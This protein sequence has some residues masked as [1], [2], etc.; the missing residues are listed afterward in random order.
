MSLR[1]L[2]VLRAVVEAGGVTRAAELLH[3][4]QPAVSAQLRAIERSFGGQLFFRAG[5]RLTLTEAGERVYQWANEVHSGGV[6]VQREVQD[7][8]A[9]LAGSLTITSSMAIGTYL[10]PGIATALLAE[11]PGA[12]I[13]VHVSEP[14][15]ALRA[16]ELG[17]SDLAVTTWLDEPVGE[18]LVSEKLWE[19]PLVLCASPDGPPEGDA[20]DLAELEGL[21]FVGAPVGVAFQ[22]MV[23]AQLRA[24]GVG[25]LDVKIRLGHAEAIK[26]AVVANRWVCLSPGYTFAEEVN[27]GR[28]RKVPIRGARLVEGIGMH[29]RRGRQFSPLQEAALEALRAV[30]LGGTA[31]PAGLATGSPD[32]TIRPMC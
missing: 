7:L 19:E 15:A 27:R 3:V 12:D 26:Q 32:L 8:A 21:P 16:V 29:Y 14:D 9:G 1:R 22:R 28:L 13:T 24:H 20:V 18:V 2:A 31:M 6:R 23:E 17:E 4:A 25:A 11:R 10:L 5:N 30:G